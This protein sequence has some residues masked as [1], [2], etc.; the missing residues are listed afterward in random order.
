MFT[1]KNLASLALQ[2]NLLVSLPEELGHLKSLIELVTTPVLC[3]VFRFRE[4]LS[5]LCLNRCFI[6][7]FFCFPTKDL[8]NNQLT[9]LPSSVGCLTCLQKL[10]L[11]HNKL[12]RLPES[13]GQLTSR[14]NFS[15]FDNKTAVA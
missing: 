3:G 4:A 13:I 10:N 8:C 11:S 14:F 15:C 12:S 7:C 6:C 2:F 9:D 1:L 5:V